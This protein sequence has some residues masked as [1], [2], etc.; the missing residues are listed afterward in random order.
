MISYFAPNEKL[1]YVVEHNKPFSKEDEQ[2]L[3]WLF[4]CNPTSKATPL[5]EGKFAGPRSEMISPW[6]TNAVEIASDMHIDGIT[7]IELLRAINNNS[8]DYDPMLEA[9][10]LSPK[11]DIFA[12]SSSVNP[13]PIKTISNIEEY[14]KTEGL[15][16]NDEEIH[17]LKSLAEKLQR[18][19]TDSEIFGFSQ[20]N[21]EHCRHK[22][23]NGTFILNGQEQP[24]SLFQLIKQTSKENPN[25]IVSAYSDNVAFL[26]GPKMLQ[27]APQQA[28]KPSSFSE[29]EITSVIS[30]KA[31]TH[32]FPTTVEPFNGAA[33]GTGGEIRDRMAGGKGSIPMAGT[34]V[35]MTS[36]PEGKANKPKHTP[37]E[38]NW[39][40]RSPREILTKAS[41][42]A[43]DFGN[44]FGQPIIAGSLLTFEH[45]EEH[46]PLQ[47]GYDKVIMLAG[48]VGYA[49]DRDAQKDSI[50]P[51]E[52]IVVMGGDN[53][54]IGMGGGA[55]SSVN[56]GNYSSGIEL[57]AVQR[58]NPEM[59]KRVQ[60]VVRA[61]AEGDNNPIHSIHDHGAGGHLNCLTELM[62]ETGGNIDINKLPIGD[63]S[64]SDRE[65]LGNE[66]QERMGIAID[67]SDY[68]RIEAIAQRER[69]PIYLVGETTSDHKLLF[70]R[71]N[72]SAAVNLPVDA[73]LAKT[74]KTVM[75]DHK[76][77]YNFASPEYNTTTPYQYLEGVLALESI[78][79]K[80]WLTNKVDRS[81]TGR[82]AR[83][84]TCGELQLPLA[85]LGAIALDFNGN[86]GIATSI[87]H[88]PRA[89]LVSSTKGSILSI[90]EALTN[91]VFAPLK[92][93]LESVSL[94]ANWMWPC[95]NEGEDYRLY[96]AVE[97][98]SNFAI[99]LGI[100]IP[101]GKDSLSM[102]QKYP[103]GKK[104]VSPGTVIISAAGE[105]KDIKK[106]VSP[107]LKPSNKSQ[108]IHIDFSYAPLALGGSALYQS[109]GYVGNDAPTVADSE[110][111]ASAFNAV[112]QIINQG[113]ALAGHDIS[114]GGLIVTLLEMAFPTTNLTASIDLT[115]IPIE[116]ITKLLYA[117]NPGVVLQV[118]DMNRVTKI[119][120]EYGVGFAL[121]GSVE[122]G[123]TLKVFKGCFDSFSIDIPSARK[124]WNEAS[125]YMD[126]FQTPIE[127][128]NERAQNI[129]E[130]PIKYTFPKGF[131]GKSQ[132]YNTT[133]RGKA[134]AA[135][136]R[137]KGS[138]GD[139]ELAYA[140]YKAGFEVRDV[141][142]TDLITGRETLE[143]VQMIGFCGGFSRSD[144]LGSAKG[145]AAAITYSPKAHQAIKNFYSR[146]NTLSIGICNGCQLM[147]LL[148]LLNNDLKPRHRMLHNK[149]GKLESIFTSV[150]IPENNS[151]MFHSLAGSSLGVWCVHG[152]GRFD[153]D[154]EIS[155]Y[156]VVAR[157]THDGYPA[158]PNG[159]PQG[160]AALASEDG[161]HLSIMPHPER[162]FLP[163]Q[164]GYYPHDR[165]T[166]EVTPWMEAFSN[167][168]NWC[169]EHK[170]N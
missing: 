108:L 80:D 78:A 164:C 137:D 120:D 21:S 118:E 19:L 161:R 25:T 104:V 43:S 23:F 146:Q 99:E 52:A 92:K 116:D 72:K 114:D 77:E 51:G 153:F 15:A 142:V 87:G 66:S 39:L 88:A 101:T 107:D 11:E 6:S 79:S 27:F 53:Y 14:N 130:Y 16:L 125:H 8:E 76:I 91:I 17:Y 65:I 168:Y 35:Y 151:V 41:N 81:V 105:V 159:S 31:E 47:Y 61:L 127:L 33:T 140:L 106:I 126:T 113:L 68:P 150:T 45:F 57:N 9:L 129:A 63:T 155:K 3:L 74:S 115:N 86:V 132:Q 96:K 162:A 48:G 38:R 154:N 28:D 89:G 165:K 55:V 123:N 124:T 152:E 84:Q 12:T 166:D 1:A 46:L 134:V 34:A 32:N 30:L 147:A 139:R 64:L 149:S 98:A 103:E 135:V 145:W 144:V 22:I 36:Y 40:Y 49:R 143:D 56:T 85:D 112:Q 122:E 50:T 141:H 169:V 128:A 160:I 44:K 133:P 117:E 167:A 69:A 2:K 24:A 71:S 83:Q 59:Q 29:K 60:N 94:S 157:Y 26:K 156:N 95:R 111:F 10:Y 75:E 100:N 5:L 136:L 102:T 148:G 119:L 73:L 58:A 13:E 90:A 82:I 109:L 121:L 4:E 170:D 138:N 131:T 97:A 67:A 54:R 110:Y 93:G 7:R 42:G 20:V 158:N 70:A 163:W 18:P 62:E 37:Q